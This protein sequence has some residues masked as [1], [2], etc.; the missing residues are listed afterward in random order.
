[1]RIAALLLFV[2]FFARCQETINLPVPVARDV[3]KELVERDKYKEQLKTSE[4]VVRLLEQKLV[5]KDT[6]ISVHKQKELNYL[7]QVSTEK[8]K[9]ELW[10][11]QYN[12]V[13]RN[14]MIQ[15]NVNK[16]QKYALAGLAIVLGVTLLN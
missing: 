9:T 8:Q 13:Y 14:Y 5:V 4:D 15:K 3:V 6:I 11:E 7:E 12:D 16:Y 10:R 1:M 2:S